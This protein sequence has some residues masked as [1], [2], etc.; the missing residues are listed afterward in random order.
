[1]E[2]GI[3]DKKSFLEHITLSAKVS[4]EIKHEQTFI[5]TAVS[6]LVLLVALKHCKLQLSR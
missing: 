4:F 1:M 6:F 2:H 5:G 3:S